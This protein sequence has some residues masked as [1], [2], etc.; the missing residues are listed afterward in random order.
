MD[1]HRLPR[2]SGI[3]RYYYE[4]DVPGEHHERPLYPWHAAYCGDIDLTGWRKPVS[5]LPQ[6]APQPPDRKKNSIWPYVSPTD[7]TDASR[8]TLPGSV[9]RHANRWNW[10]STRRQKDIEVEIYTT[11]PAVK[12]YLGEPLVGTQRRFEEYRTVFTPAVPTR[13]NTRRSADRQREKRS[14]HALSPPGELLPPYARSADR[15]ALNADGGDTAF[16][17]VEVVDA[18][19]RSLVPY[20]RFRP[21]PTRASPQWQVPK[22]RYSRQRPVFSMPHTTWKDAR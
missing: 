16:V 18:Q 15:T 17:T 19:G 8:K 12:L 4:G 11:Y 10:P 3:G 21:Q 14:T 1:C 7:T 9:R 5:P 22:R 13:N 20:P 2:E 6:H